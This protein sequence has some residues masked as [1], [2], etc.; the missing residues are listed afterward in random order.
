MGFNR[1]SQP[2]GGWLCSAYDI[3][4][5]VS[6]LSSLEL[7]VGG[8]GD[9]LTATV[10]MAAQSWLPGNMDKQ[11]GRGERTEGEQG[12]RRETVLQCRSEEQGSKMTDYQKFICEIQNCLFIVK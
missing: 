3:M 12:R 2:D 10:A 6:S 4:A 1:S 8:K 9:L 11:R 7:T 5:I